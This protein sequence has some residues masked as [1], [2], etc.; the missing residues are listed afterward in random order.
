MGKPKWRSRT[1]KADSKTSPLNKNCSG[2]RRKYRR[3][4][5]SLLSTVKECRAQLR[6]IECWTSWIKKP[7]KKENSCLESDQRTRE[8]MTKPLRRESPKS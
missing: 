4:I 2:F 7:T 8:L 6:R 1:L 3:S 5:G